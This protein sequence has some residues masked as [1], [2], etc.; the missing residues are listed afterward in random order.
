MRRPLLRLASAL[1]ALALSYPSGAR[2][3]GDEG[4][5][6][7][8]SVS[9]TRA[10][11]MCF[12]DRVEVTGTLVPR[13]Q[14]DVGPEREGFKVTQVL[15]S[16]LDEVTAGQVLARLQPLDGGS[17]AA[18]SVAVRS[19]VSGILLRSGAVVGMPA[20]SRLGPLFQIVV[21][22]DFD[23]QAEV[24]LSD[25]K[26]LATGQDVTVRPLG[27][28]EMAAKVLRVESGADAASQLGRVRIGLFAGGEVRVGTFARGVVVVAK[29]CGV[30]VPYSAVMYESDA[31]IVQVVSDGRIES[32]QVAVGLLSGDNAEIRSGVGEADRVVVRAGPF[33]REGD[34]VKPIEIKA[35]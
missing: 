15:A 2:A 31:T 26:K 1:A 35:K 12:E 7:V 13:Q 29:R 8:L 10:R 4:R 9:V 14:A 23:L 21:G 28:P 3:A 24:P 5:A 22:G 33:V 34:P 16:P 20:S 25:L 30:G 27:L 11:S 32:R 17:G 6:D 18:T 19:P